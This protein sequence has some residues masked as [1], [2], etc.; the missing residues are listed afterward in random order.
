[1]P[2]QRPLAAAPLTLG[3]L[4]W[5][6]PLAQAPGWTQPA[7]G[8]ADT[9]PEF[10]WETNQ[11]PPSGLPP[12][13]PSPPNF[14]VPIETVPPVLTPDLRDRF[15]GLP[16][17]PDFDIY[18]LGPGDAIFVSVQRFGDLSFEA[19]LDLQGNVVVPLVGAV[20]LEGLT[21]E[22]AEAKI[23]SLY[24]QYVVDPDVSLTLVAQRS[25]EVTVLGEVVRPG[26]Y[27]LPAP[28]VSTALLAS[29]GATGT[30]DLRA[31][32]IQRQLPEGQTIEETIDLFT[33]L[34]QGKALPDLRLDD[35]DV[36][37]IPRLD[38][39]ELD[40]Y[41]RYLVSRSTLAQ[42][43][44][45][46]RA[47]T[48]STNGGALRTVELPNGSRFLDAITTIGVNA[49]RNALRDVGLIRFDPELGKAVTLRLNTYEALDGDLSQ[50]PPLET[51]DVIIVNRNLVSRITYAFNTFT[52]PFRD[53][54]GF[55]LFFESISD[56]ATNLFGPGS[57]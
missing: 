42:P 38:P 35:G 27:P 2:L 12:A 43:Q 56:A 26:F 20:S 16:T 39:S 3:L 57:N 45:S 17:E 48:Y 4:L 32:Q 9:L 50:N 21:L 23:R 34:L 51:N 55:L 14:P 25:V 7:A 44:V 40:E 46:I 18:R 52:Q 53:V 29:G 41:D 1:M 36:V 22:Q 31:V 8:E 49:D 28:T 5:L 30:A 15:L 47:L 33:P 37:F 19:T 54:L 13:L 10:D 11:I 6:S 24:D